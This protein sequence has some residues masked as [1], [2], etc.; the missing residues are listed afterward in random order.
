MLIIAFPIALQ[1][2]IMS[3]LNMIDTVMIGKLGEIEIAAV[4]LANQFFFLFILIVFGVNSGASIFISQ[5]WGKKDVVNIRKVLGISLLLGGLV[6]LV[7]AGTAFFLSKEI[8]RIFSKDIQVIALGSDYL[9]IVCLSYLPTACS[10]AYSFSLRSIGKANTPMVVSS[11]SLIA[12]TIL[13]YLFIFGNLGFPAMGVKGAAWAT[14]IARV[15]ELIIFVGVVY[16]RKEALAAKINEI[17][18]ISMDFLW[19]FLNTTIPVILNETFWA[20]G[21]VMYIIAYAR[22]S[23][24]AIAS[25]QIANTI[26]HVFMIVAFGLGNACAIMIGNKI[27]A[28]EK[29]QAIAYAKKFVV[30]SIAVGMILGILLFISIPFILN[31]FN[32]S[33]IVYENTVKVLTVL[34]FFLSLRVLNGVIIIGILRG[35]GDTKFSLVLDV[36]SVWLVGVP[37]AFLGAHVWKFPVYWVVALVSIEE[38]VKLIF[39]LWR[40]RSKKWVSNVIE[41]M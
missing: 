4:G 25:V 27:G 18:N 31:L 14:L 30:L 8:L 23:T 35:G 36:G 17:F 37:L 39:G 5:F 1:N 33:S 28:N 32:V 15:L 24:E 6:S 2:L 9:S 3:F 34:S 21:T 12:N 10:F 11:I 41:H 19:K 38:M 22:I 13:N 26:Q 20:L 7:F 29:L 40:V 16:Y